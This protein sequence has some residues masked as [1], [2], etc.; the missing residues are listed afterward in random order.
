[1]NFQISCGFVSINKR[2]VWSR[3][4]I[5]LE[6][7]PPICWVWP[8]QYWNRRSGVKGVNKSGLACKVSQEVIANSIQQWAT[9]PLLPHCRNML[10]LAVLFFFFERD[11]SLVIQSN[12]IFSSNGWPHQLITAWDSDQLDHN[13]LD[14]L[15]KLAN[16][17]LLL[18]AL[19]WWSG[20]QWTVHIERN[21]TVWLSTHCCCLLNIVAAYFNYNLLF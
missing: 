14:I 5:P 15:W 10:P 17:L 16:G 13:S 7:L 11:P 18:L 20:G 1:M 3:A 4:H 9:Q 6:G 12:S 21:I 2:T 19:W 8:Q